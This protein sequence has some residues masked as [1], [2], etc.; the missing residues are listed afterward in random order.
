MERGLMTLFIIWS[1][2]S[3]ITK[4]I[5]IR[6]KIELLFYNID[7]STQINKYLYF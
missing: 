2:I 4:I 6:N 3:N 7:K 1:F 5:V